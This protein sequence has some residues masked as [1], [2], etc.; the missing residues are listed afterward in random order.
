MDWTYLVLAC[1]I[2]WVREVTQKWRKTSLSN[3]SPVPIFESSIFFNQYSNSHKPV[4][5]HSLWLKF[6]ST[7][8]QS[9]HV[10]VCY[11]KDNHDHF[12]T[13][14]TY[15]YAKSIDNMMRVLC[16]KKR[17]IGMNDWRAICLFNGF[18]NVVCKCAIEE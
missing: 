15:E 1:H 4:K 7:V 14:F 12:K 13:Y 18:W 10:L 6:L 3:S 11:S 5:V 16:R 2:L 9:L 17:A 8:I